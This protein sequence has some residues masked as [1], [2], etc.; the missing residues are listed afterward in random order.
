MLDNNEIIKIWTQDKVHDSANTNEN[1]NDISDLEE[2][3]PQVKELISKLQSNL[4]SV[5][6]VK[7]KMPI[8][9]FTLA[10][11]KVKLLEM[12]FTM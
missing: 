8:Q 10:S 7:I 4:S 12:Y 5:K 3:S 1:V 9:L 6:K 11:L 2:M